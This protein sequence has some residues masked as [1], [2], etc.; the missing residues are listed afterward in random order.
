MSN[1]KDEYR[2]FAESERELPIFMQPSYLDAVVGVSAWDVVL[3]LSGGKVMAVHPFVISKFMGKTALM[4]PAISQ[5]LGP[6][7]SSS[8][9]SDKEKQRYLLEIVESLPRYSYYNQNWSMSIR[10]W[11]PFYWYG[12]RQTCRYSYVLNLL[13]TDDEIWANLSSSYRNKIRKVSKL[14]LSITTD[15]DPVDFFKLQ[16]E[17]FKRQNLNVPM[18]LDD[19]LIWDKR[20]ND[21]GKRIILGCV[22]D[23][24]NLLCGAYLLFDN[25]RCYLNMFG[26]TPES[27]NLSTGIYLLW[28]TV[29][30]AKDSLRVGTFDFQGSMI[31]SIEITR[32]D[33]GGEQEMY[34]NVSRANDFLSKAYLALKILI[35]G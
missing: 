6:Y 2:I 18:K 31:K 21:L 20:L 10:N 8:I 15:L 17:V 11:L 19:F 5:F 7:F 26:E 14:N 29:I 35:R 30:F 27:R 16:V 24:G 22:N 4:Q 34:F 28:K 3:V 12:F 1:S 33:F 9:K 23:S 25:D 32:R 13:K